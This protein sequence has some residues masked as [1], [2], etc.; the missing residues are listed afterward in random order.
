M[1]NLLA[2]FA[3]GVASIITGSVWYGPLFGKKWMEI[4]K[5]SAED[6]A[7]RAEMQKAALP[8]YLVQFILSLFQAFILAYLINAHSTFSSLHL[9]IL[10]WAAFIMPTVAGSSMWNNDTKNIKWTKF[11]IQASY[12][13]LNMVVFGLI[14]AYWQ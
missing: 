10:I 5:V 3:C 11:L 1:P 8:L 6:L 12:Q 2:V 14:I 7:K 9:S 13:L 4:C